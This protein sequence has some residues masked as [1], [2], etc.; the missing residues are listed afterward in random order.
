LEEPGSLG[1]RKPIGQQGSSGLKYE[2][3][4]EENPETMDN[5]AQK[6]IKALSDL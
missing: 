4:N 1:P 5:L 6:E 2:P 3:G